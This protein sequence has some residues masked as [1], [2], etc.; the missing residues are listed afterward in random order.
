MGSVVGPPLLPPTYNCCGLHQPYYLLQGVDFGVVLGKHLLL[1][2]Q[3]ASTLK[4][5]KKL[6]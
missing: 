4:K 2:V 5:R 6:E 1:M 3:V